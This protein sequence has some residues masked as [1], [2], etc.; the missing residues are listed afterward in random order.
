M[1]HQFPGLRI[2]EYWAAV[3][4]DLIALVAAVAD[5]DLNWRSEDGA[6]SCREQALHIAG[7]RHRW[8]SLSVRDGRPA[9]DLRAA[10]RTTADV[11]HQLAESWQRLAAFLGDAAALDREYSSADDD[12]L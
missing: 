5:D 2:T 8:L 3:N 9:P 12:G 4:D 6:W 1:E 7:S 11:L 10:G